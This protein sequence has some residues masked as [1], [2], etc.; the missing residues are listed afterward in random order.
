MSSSSSSSLSSLDPKTGFNSK[1]HTFHSLHPPISLPKNPSLSFPSFAFSLLSS[2]SSNFAIADSSTALSLSS[3]QFLSQVN[4]LS[5]S[6]KTQLNLSIGSVAF[7]LS[8][9]H[10]HVPILYFSL[11]QIGA[12][13]SP[14]NPSSTPREISRQIQLINPSIAFVTSST[15]SN[16]PTHVPKILIDTPHFVSLLNPD[17]KVGSF[18]TRYDD[19]QQSDTA[20]ILFSSGTTGHVKG[21]ILT[22]KNLIAA[23]LASSAASGPVTIMITVPL[24]HVFG[25]LCLVKAVARGERVVIMTGRFEA[26]QVLRAVEMFRVTNLVLV[27]PALLRIVREVEEGNWGEVDLSSLV[28][29]SSGG[30]SVGMGVIRRFLKRFPNVRVGQGYGLTES[31]AGVFRVASPEECRHLG[32]AGRLLPG[33]EAKIVDPS[34]GIDLH[35]CKQG[36]LWVRGP[37]IMKGYI[38]NEEATSAILDAEGWLKTGDLCYIDDD[39]YLFVVDR[40][41]E[42]IKY[43][44]YQVPPAELEHLVQTHDDIIEAAVIPYPDDEAGQVPMAFVVRKLNSSVGEAEIMEFVAKQV[45]AYKKIRRVSFVNSIPKNPAGKILRKELIKLATTKINPKL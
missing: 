10:L 43:K 35:P 11:L 23:T 14:S 27:P 32:S 39:G 41:K 29:V 37:T 8:P 3:S 17:K 16:L 22:H 26:R 25:L 31:T 20:A 24:F 9:P 34:T 40:L 5:F 6:L 28:V 21:V 45:A 30:A 12:I 44:G 42:L 18:P 15:A 4:S 38:G 36:E 7:I 19:I 2:S 33:C 13:I 1:T